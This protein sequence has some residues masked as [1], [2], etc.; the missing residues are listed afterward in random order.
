MAVDGDLISGAEYSSVNCAVFM[1]FVYMEIGAVYN[2]DLAKA[3]CCYGGMRSSATL[4]G[5]QAVA[6]EDH[7]DIVRHGIGPHQD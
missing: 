5:E 2:T 7:A 4:C 1:R 6:F 3:D